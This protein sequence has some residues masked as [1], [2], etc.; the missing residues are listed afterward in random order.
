MPTNMILYTIV[1][2]LFTGGC[3]ALSTPKSR[4]VSSS[5]STCLGLMPAFEEEVEDDDATEVERQVLRPTMT[6]FEVQGPMLQPEKPKI[7]VLGASGRIGR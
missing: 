5:S 3:S 6:E 1:L 7:V 4:V 2:L